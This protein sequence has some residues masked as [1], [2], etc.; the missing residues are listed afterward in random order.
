MWKY[1]CSTQDGGQMI[2]LP[3]LLVNE[4]N[5]RARDLMVGPYST[6]CERSLP[7]LMDSELM[8]CPIPRRSTAA[9][10]SCP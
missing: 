3:L 8:L 9:R 6:H 10:F 5:F 2:Y 1:T 7:A 4:L